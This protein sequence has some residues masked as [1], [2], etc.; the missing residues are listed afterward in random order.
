MTK[1]LSKEILLSSVEGGRLAVGRSLPSF[2]ESCGCQRIHVV[3]GFAKRGRC[4]LVELK[5]LHEY[6]NGVCI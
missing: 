5:C 3:V 4:V 6:E 2:C 1:Y